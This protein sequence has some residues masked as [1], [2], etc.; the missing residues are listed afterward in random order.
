MVR[1]RRRRASRT[2]IRRSRAKRP[3]RSGIKPG[4]RRSSRGQPRRPDSKRRAGQ[5]VANRAERFT[6]APDPHVYVP[7]PN[8][9]QASGERLSILYLVHV[10]YPE[11]FTGTEKFVLNMARSM[12]GKGHRVKVVTCGQTVAEDSL[13]AIGDVVWSEYEY[14]GVPVLAYRHRRLD[15]AASFQ[16]ADASLPAFAEHILE[17]EQPSIVHIGHPSR[18]LDF[19][20]AAKRRGIPYVITLTDFWM[21]CP[22]SLLLRDNLE[23][24][25]G[26]E[27]GAAC[28]AHCGLA[29][30]SER[31]ANYLPILESASRLLSP[32]AFLASM[33][34]NVYPSLRVDVLNHGLRPESLVPNTKV[35]DKRSPLTLVYGGSITRHKG[36]HV[37]VQAMSWVPSSRLRLRIYGSGDPEYTNA[38]REMASADPRIAFYGPYSEADIPRIYRE[39][40]VAVVPSIWYENYPFALNEA[41]ASRVPALVSNIGGMAEAVRDGINGLTFQAGSARD[42][43]RRIERLLKAPALLNSLK[44]NL[45][46]TPTRTVEDE[47]FAY[48]NVYFAHAL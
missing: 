32:S 22:K 37:L 7:Q 38:V 26:P 4:G 28:L 9:R 8:S 10:F 21:V 14:E 35:Y 12:Q 18:A 17:R 24:C 30:V 41:L 31:L 1:I 2:A 3:R 43:A 39:S 20:Q 25:S 47:A 44:R 11:S 40:D 23:L 46:N 33:V 15:P 48:E 19:V 29:N 27:G 42:L 45:R 34:R 13:N 16:I 5:K 36:V 6:P